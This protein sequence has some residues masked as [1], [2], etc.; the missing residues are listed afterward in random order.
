MIL[1]QMLFSVCVCAF[2]LC[3]FAV[4]HLTVNFQLRWWVVT[5]I[6]RN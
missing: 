6:L 3:C 2:L 5:F 1:I 4:S